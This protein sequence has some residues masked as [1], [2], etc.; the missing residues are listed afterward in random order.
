MLEY[1]ENLWN[2][3]A[4]TQDEIDKN[5]QMLDNELITMKKNM[6]ASCFFPS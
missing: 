6:L 4:C 3:E 5:L 2:N 1:I